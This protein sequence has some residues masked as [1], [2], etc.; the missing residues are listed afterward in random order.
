[1]KI[2]IVVYI[3]LLVIDILTVIY[4]VL[5]KGSWRGIGSILTL[6][7]LAIANL[8]YPYNKGTAVCGGFVLVFAGIIIDEMILKKQQ[9][10][11]KG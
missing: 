6:L 10:G 5:K 8:V 1:M 11:E 2:S 7:G 4:R 3:L 9:D